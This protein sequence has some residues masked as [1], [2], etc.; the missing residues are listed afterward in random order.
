MLL[1]DISTFKSYN[2]TFVSITHFS[3]TLCHAVLLHSIEHVRTNGLACSVKFPYCM[4]TIDKLQLT[5]Y[6]GPLGL[7][8]FLTP[9]QGEPLVY[10][11]TTMW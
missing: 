7:S 1:K 9:L 8:V 11:G 3:P 2:I 6:K 10:S 5:S 4:T